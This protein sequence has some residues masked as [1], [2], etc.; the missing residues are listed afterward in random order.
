MNQKI[1]KV[2]DLILIVIIIIIIWA[3]SGIILMDIDERGT[4]GDMFGVVTSLFTGLALAGLIISIILQRKEVSIQKE[5]LIESRVEFIKQNTILS[6]QRFE[7]TLFQL[8]GLHHEIIDHF[9]YSVFSNE[10]NVTYYKREVFTEALKYLKSTNEQ[11]YKTYCRNNNITPKNGTYNNI[12]EADESIKVGY[13]YFNFVF[14]KILN[15]YYR[16]LFQI[17]NFIYQSENIST[18]EKMFY[19]SIVSS[20]LSN[21]ELTLLLYNSLVKGSGYPNF[22][23]LIKEFNLINNQSKVNVGKIIFELFKSKLEDVEYT[24]I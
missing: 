13:K 16:N 5:E 21:E 24:F 12:T 19:S 23:Y 11:A 14:A 4:L 8:I 18:K 9:Q 10:V 22:L 7:N 20:Q 17:F 1:F 6:K 15:H 3:V 2:K